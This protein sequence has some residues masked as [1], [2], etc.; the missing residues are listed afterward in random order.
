MCCGVVGRDKDKKLAL[1]CA[2]CVKDW[3]AGA[4]DAQKARDEDAPP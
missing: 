2:E 1:F 3:R 4:A